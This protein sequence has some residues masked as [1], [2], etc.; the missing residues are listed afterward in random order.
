MSL[1]VAAQLGAHMIYQARR[2]N[3]GKI[4]GDYLILLHFAGGVPQEKQKEPW[5]VNCEGCILLPFGVGWCGGE[6]CGM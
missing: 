5:L 4:P 1:S 6:A 2:D 3:Q